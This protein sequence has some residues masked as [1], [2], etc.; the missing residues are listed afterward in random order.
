MNRF[1]VVAATALSV[2][3]GAQALAQQVAVEIAPP[4]RTTIKEYVVKE[5]V[6]PVT[7]QEKV[8]IGAT[9]PSDVE[10]LSVPTAWGPSV[11][12]Y[13][14]VY[15]DNRVVLVEPSNRKVIQIID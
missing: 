10:L 2:A 6:K 11:S 12:K 8:T 13:R 3:F 4:M 5:K 9:L 14:Y 15:H 7:I 1:A